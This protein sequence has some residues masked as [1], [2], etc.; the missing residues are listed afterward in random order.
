MRTNSIK[1]ITG[2]A[3]LLGLFCMPYVM[4]D[5][6]IGMVTGSKTGTYLQF[7][8]DISG[9]A[10]SA[11]LEILVKES[12]GSIDNIKRLNS[13]ENAT[14]GIV[15]SDVLGF[16][17]RSNNPEMQR[18]ASRI[19]LVFPFY[20]E[21]VHLFANKKIQRFSDLEGKRVIL[22]EKSSGNWL[23]ATNLL[24][25]T[26][27]KPGEAL[28]LPPLEAVTAVLKGEADAMIYVAG[29]P[30]QL[31]TKLGNLKEKPDFAPLFENVHFVPLDD[32]VMLREY[33]NSEIGP[34]DYNWVNKKIPTIAVKAVLMSFDF[35]NKKTPYF[36][37]R[38]QELAKIGQ[39]VRNN[40]DNLKQDGHP[41]WKEVNLEERIGTWE[42]DTCSREGAG[43]PG[44]KL[45]IGKELEKV[46]LNQLRPVPVVIEIAQRA[47]AH[48]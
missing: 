1:G 8:K 3:F 20:K 2:I 7:G 47:L 17:S 37:Q 44:L 35:S 36:R 15:Q 32:T 38:C 25:M 26:G 5:E 41:K 29:K 28:Y 27:V 24:Q 18:I 48:R 12:E 45:D 11:G 33:E 21:E 43:K 39:A 10:K 22:G 42:L 19:R 6:G 40:I 13:S 9:A 4:A 16:L 31:F 23:T 46:L 30:V 34:Q 14:L